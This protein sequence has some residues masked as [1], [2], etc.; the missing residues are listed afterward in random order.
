MGSINLGYYPFSEDS[1]GRHL[2]KILEAVKVGH[3]VHW[4]HQ[5]EEVVRL[6]QEQLLPRLL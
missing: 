2:E 5:F 6:P 3:R 4:R 1:Y